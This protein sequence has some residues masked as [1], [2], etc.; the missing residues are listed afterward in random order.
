MPAEKREAFVTVP[1]GR[2][3]ESVVRVRPI[4]ALLT[5]L[6][7]NLFVAI[8]ILRQIVTHADYPFDLDEA[9]HA[10]GALALLLGF[11]AGG[12]DGLLHAFFEQGFYPP[13]FALFQFLGFAVL[14]VSATLARMFS[15]SALFFGVLVIYA[16]C[17]EVDKERGWLAG[18]IACGAT[19][20]MLP[21][22]I[23]SALVMKEAPGVL[24]SFLFLW[25]YIR[26]FRHNTPQRLA[27]SG[28]LLLL[29]FLT[30][31]TY[32]LA[33]LATAVVVELSLLPWRRL[34]QHASPQRRLLQRPLWLFG[35][36]L[37]GI[38]AWFA[39]PG[40][41]A[42]FLAYVTAQPEGGLALSLESLLFY[43]RSIALAQTPAPI[44]TL[45]TALSLVWSLARRRHV[46]VR[47]LLIYFL[48]G[49][50]MMTLNRP[51]NPRFIATFVPAAHILTGLMV[52]RLAVQ[53]VAP[54]PRLA[55]WAVVLAIIAF[56]LPNVVE[57]FR[58]YP[59]TV[60]AAYETDPRLN[61]LAQWIQDQVPAGRRFYLINYWDQ[62]G[63][64]TLAWRLGQEAIS[65][66]VESDFSGVLMPGALLDPA[67]TQK[68]QELRQEIL[69][70]GVS[71]VVVLEGGPWGSPFWPHYTAALEDRLAMVADHT[72]SIGSGGNVKVIVY[73]VVN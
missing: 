20:T 61:D 12:P 8:F 22:L 10:N 40:N 47:L 46:A 35:P 68:T 17:V 45:L 16:I 63:P 18:I 53:P 26:T 41:V 73:E 57:R 15:L 44:F 55:G 70:S 49:M 51:Q 33:T 2:I 39:Y 11:E 30:K 5:V 48:V 60:N 37:L 34:L 50:A 28:A 19:L 7:A 36:F 69:E 64:Q 62:F 54:R 25:A 42:Q 31:Y 71:Y 38:I 52:A 27:L 66:D 13:A 23:N 65:R 1:A 3:N 43:P 29:V 14:D 4:A 59:A 67:S 32:G 24:V 72:Q 9:N 58:Q 6:L 56:S 21:L